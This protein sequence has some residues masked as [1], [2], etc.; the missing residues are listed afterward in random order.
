MNM[1]RRSQ[2][3]TKL[4]FGFYILN[5]NSYELIYGAL[6]TIPVFMVWVYLCWIVL[7]IGA[8][9]SAILKNQEEEKLAE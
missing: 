5:F 8:L 2:E 9:I 7:L 3:I 4:G 1:N 6:A